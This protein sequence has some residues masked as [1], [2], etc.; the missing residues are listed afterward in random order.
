MKALP[1]FG[2]TM[3]APKRFM[4]ADK[5]IRHVMLT[6]ETTSQCKSAERLPRKAVQDTLDTSYGMRGRRLSW[7]N[8]LATIHRASP[9][10][11][12][13]SLS[14][15]KGTMRSLSPEWSMSTGGGGIGGAAAILYTATGA[16][17][18]AVSITVARPAA[19]RLLE[20]PRN[21]H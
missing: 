3:Y 21:I 10:L 17:T 9:S 19:R 7:D 11:L 14:Q 13:H 4:H 12:P 2:L 16:A 18:A 20:A 15:Q 6:R 1:R 5:Q 8:L